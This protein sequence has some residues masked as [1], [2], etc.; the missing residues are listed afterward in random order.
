MEEERA[1][2]KV[3]ET[4][5]RAEEIK[6]LKKRNEDAHRARQE[7]ALARQMEEKQ[8]RDKVQKEKEMRRRKVEMTRKIIEDSR[9]EEVR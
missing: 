4:Q 9:K 2:Q 6:L 5:E 1:R 3:M 8:I 7:A